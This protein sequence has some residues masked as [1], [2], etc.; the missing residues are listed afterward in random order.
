[1]ELENVNRAL[2][3]VITQLIDEET[4]TKLQ[5]KD[6]I[7]NGLRQFI[8]KNTDYGYIYDDKHFLCK[9][10]QKSKTLRKCFMCNSI[11]CSQC[12]IQYCD[13]CHDYSCNSPDCVIYSSNYHYGAYN[14]HMNSYVYGTW[15]TSGNCTYQGYGINHPDICYDIDDDGL[16]HM[17]KP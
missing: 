10:G 5:E 6:D 14:K 1:M 16:I 7:I 9:C 2:K 8:K 12:A 13:E 17:Y 4:K 15:C 3:V 11:V